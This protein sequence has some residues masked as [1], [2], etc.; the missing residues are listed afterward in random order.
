MPTQNTSAASATGIAS[1]RKISVTP[2]EINS[3]LNKFEKMEFCNCT[4][5]QTWLLLDDMAEVLRKIVNR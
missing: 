3:V 2:E 1:E 5:I 4:Q